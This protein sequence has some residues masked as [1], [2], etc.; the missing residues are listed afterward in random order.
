[1]DTETMKYYYENGLWSLDR[2]DKLLNSGKITLE[3]YNE[4]TGVE[5][6]G[7]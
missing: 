3:Q 7:F 5:Q 1:M 6:E 2:L 4:I